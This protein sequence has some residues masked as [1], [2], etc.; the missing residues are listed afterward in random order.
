MLRYILLIPYF[1]Y[2]LFGVVVLINNDSQNNCYIFEYVISAMCFQ[3]ILVLMFIKNC[4]TDRNHWFL[5]TI[6][7]ITFTIWGGIL[8]VHAF[9]VY[10]F[11][12]YAE[13]VYSRHLV[14]I[15]AS[16]FY[17]FWENCDALILYRDRRFIGSGFMV[18]RCS[19]VVCYGFRRAILM[20]FSF[21]RSAYRCRVL[22]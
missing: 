8:F 12:V 17:V 14:H 22:F 6:C 7:G 15:W 19:E 21:S 3:S 9:V 5:L 18:L 1:I 4:I 20:T 11:E 2:L 16:W 13:A 10:V